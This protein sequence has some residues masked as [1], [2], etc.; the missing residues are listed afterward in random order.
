MKFLIINGPNLNLLARMDTDEY[1]IAEMDDIRRFWT[2]IMN[3]KISAPIQHSLKASELLARSYGMFR[4]TIAEDEER[5]LNMPD[6]SGYT[7][8][9]LR[10]IA[11]SMDEF[12]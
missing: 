1:P 7:M 6:M 12:I 2:K 11:Y 5:R 10:K 3:G 4:E 8:D 9:E